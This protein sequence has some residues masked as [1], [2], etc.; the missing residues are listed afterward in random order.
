[1]QRHSRAALACTAVVLTGLIAGPGSA[2]PAPAPWSLQRCLAATAERLDFTGAASV[3]RHGVLSRHARGL[4]GGP[5]SPALT[6][7]DRFN[8]ASEGK[9]FT[10]VAVAQLIDG[11]RV[12]LD[13]A[14][15]RYVAGLTPE[16]SAVTVRQLLTHSSGL[17]DYISP[18][19][20]AVMKA[21]SLSDL[22]PLVASDRPAFT[23][24]SRF[25]YSNSGFL[26]LG[27]LIE[28]VSGQSYG[29]Y[30]QAHIF[31]PAGMTATGL[32]P[33]APRPS[34]IGLTAMG[35]DGPLPAGAPLR[36]APV[37]RGSA[38][39]GAFST[40]GDMQ[41]FFAALTT[42]KLVR[43]ETYLMMTSPQIVAAPAKG[44]TPEFDYGLGFGV[45][46]FKGHRWFGH[47]GGA[48]GA[49]DEAVVFP[50][51]AT[52]LV[53]MSNRDPPLA[54]HFF[55][56]VRGFAFSPAEPPCEGSSPR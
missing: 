25:G 43:P 53:V 56:E 16:T 44:D 24:G 46:M 40:A 31:Q 13:D 28:A 51:D 22:K 14:I 5:G 36:P 47:N 2:A 4:A 54:S 23:P 50:D 6:P 9:M 18:N 35:P 34:A 55:R 39:G 10:A 41:R 30:L 29:D 7:D 26:V 8:L 27:L 1:M 42:G 52:S 33:D 15:G 11:G 49:N 17:G 3:S 20:P 19:F 12:R 21:R 45:G 32:D 38:A 37:P 48:P